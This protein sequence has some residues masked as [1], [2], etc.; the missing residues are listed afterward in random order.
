MHHV[1]K[2]ILLKNLVLMTLQNIM[3]HGNCI[4]WKAANLLAY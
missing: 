1:L 2:F 4:P 3:G